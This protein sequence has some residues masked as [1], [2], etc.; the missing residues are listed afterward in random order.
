MENKEVAQLLIEQVKARDEVIKELIEINKSK[1]NKPEL[2]VI[3]TIATFMFVIMLTMI[4][5][6]FF[7]NYDYVASNTSINNSNSEEKVGN[8]NE[9]EKK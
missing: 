7:S 6:Y 9:D 4:F 8:S 3:L 2:T 5:S 1:Q